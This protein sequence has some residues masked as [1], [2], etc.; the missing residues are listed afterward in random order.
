VQI[1]SAKGSRKLWIERFALGEA[2][3]QIKGGPDGCPLDGC[4]QTT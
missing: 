1:Q 2:L 3:R 4:R